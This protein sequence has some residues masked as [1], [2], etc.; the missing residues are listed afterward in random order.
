M[1]GFIR[2]RTESGATNDSRQENPVPFLGKLGCRNSLVLPSLILVPLAFLAI[3]F[4]NRYAAQ[5]DAT[6][7]VARMAGES[8][9]HLSDRL[10]NDLEKAHMLVDLNVLAIKAGEING[11][12]LFQ[13][14]EA[15]FLNRLKAFPTVDDV[16]LGRHDGAIAGIDHKDDQYQL[17]LTTVFPKRDFI[18]L[19]TLGRRRNVIAQDTYDA[20]SRGWYQQAL[21]RNGGVWSDV[22]VL[23]NRGQIGIT[24]ARPAYDPDGRLVGVIG[25]NLTL[26]T[27]SDYLLAAPISEHSI[28]YIVER[29]GRLIATSTRHD[30]L[31]AI[32]P[33]GKP[34][35]QTAA[36][37]DDPRI[38]ESYRRLLQDG[39]LP[40][41][42]SADG[43]ALRIDGADYLLYAS[44]FR[45]DRG[46]DWHVVSVVRLDDFTG[47]ADARA[48][49][50]LIVG[51]LLTLA[52][53]LTVALIGK[54]GWP[55][56][57]SVSAPWHA[58]WR[59]A[60][61]AST[62]TSTAARVR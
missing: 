27:I 15:W 24:A 10:R 33:N 17:K 21:T 53:T 29:D 37:V 19:D 6:R 12:T 48:R 34:A 7:L 44:P 54:C 46:L 52:L 51:L 31:Q 58:A 20:T 36:S 9:A 41:R 22:Y 4:L 38:A 30:V 42:P 5:H 32:G 35:R 56:P 49:D 59:R 25:A 16:Y 45:D 40:D 23:L 8:T 3:V 55:I 18:A 39:R 47:E 57:S 1:S 14:P 13:R 50:I 26:K 61:Q 62:S 43:I 11:T 2:S 60:P 28:A